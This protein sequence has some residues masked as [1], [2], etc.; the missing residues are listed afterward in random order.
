MN[1]KKKLDLVWFY[2]LA[3]KNPLLDL[4]LQESLSSLLSDVALRRLAVSRKALSGLFR[5][6]ITSQ[7]KEMWP[8]SQRNENCLLSSISLYRKLCV[9]HW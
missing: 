5:F 4:S 6:Y 7:W 3:G 8:F 2:I 1:D 9:G